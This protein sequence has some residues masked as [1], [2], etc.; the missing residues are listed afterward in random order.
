MVLILQFAKRIIDGEPL[1]GIDDSNKYRRFLEKYLL[2][3]SDVVENTCLSCGNTD[4]NET[5]RW[6][7]CNFCKRWLHDLPKC[8][9]S[10]VDPNVTIS[11]EDV[12]YMCYLCAYHDNKRSLLK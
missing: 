4:L 5:V 2:E 3:E 8:T 10:T 11:S 6:V 9:R 7:Q 12:D 1:T